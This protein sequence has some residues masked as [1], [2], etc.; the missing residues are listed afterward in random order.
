MAPL[1]M[2]APSCLLITIALAVA[3]DYEIDNLR[4]VFPVGWRGISLCFADLSH[5]KAL[6]IAETTAR[7]AENF[8]RRVPFEYMIA[9]DEEKDEEGLNRR[10]LRDYD[11]PNMSLICPRPGEMGSFAT[12]IPT[13]LIDVEH[14]GGESSGSGE[15]GGASLPILCGAACAKDMCVRV[16]T[17]A[18]RQRALHGTAGPTQRPDSPAGG[19]NAT[20]SNNNHYDH[21]L[22]NNVSIQS[23]RRVAFVA[24][25]PST[26]APPLVLPRQN[27]PVPRLSFSL[28]NGPLAA[29]ADPFVE[30][31]EEE[32]VGSFC[33]LMPPPGSPRSFANFTGDDGTEG[34]EE[35]GEGST[36]EKKKKKQKKRKENTKKQKWR[37]RRRKRTKEGDFEREVEKPWQAMQLRVMLW[38]TT[39]CCELKRERRLMQDAIAQHPSLH[40]V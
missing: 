9:L 15:E 18:F 30:G 31:F 7:A 13:V 24:R 40:L 3:G 4:I 34:E 12:G 25:Q 35:T 23:S 8:C 28:V 14:S 20:S 32:R 22:S 11:I 36:P 39:H 6:P 10:P 26:G 33:D 5:D 2:V 17:M 21:N 19:A 16:L 27:L 1:R 29:P 38:T 37:R